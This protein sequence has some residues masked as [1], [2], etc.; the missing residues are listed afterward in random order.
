MKEL[1]SK[2]GNE[3]Y[4]PVSIATL[5]VFAQWL[6]SGV[7]SATLWNFPPFS[8]SP[9]PHLSLYAAP[10]LDLLT[11]AWLGSLALSVLYCG[12]N[13][14]GRLS[15]LGTA[16]NRLMKI[17]LLF[18]PALVLW[19]SMFAE[20]SFL[21]PS[22]AQTPLWFG[23]A[24]PLS[25]II[26]RSVETAIDRK[27]LGKQGLLSIAIN[28]ALIVA[29]IGMRSIGEGVYGNVRYVSSRIRGQP[30]EVVPKPNVKPTIGALLLF[31]SI[32]SMTVAYEM[33]YT[34]MLELFYA[35]GVA[36]YAL[37]I[38]SGV[39]GWR[40]LKREEV[41]KKR[42]VRVPPRF[43]SK[44]NFFVSAL[45]IRFTRLRRLITG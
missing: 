45:S 2:L 27:I 13:R 15:W 39:V 23:S 33:G 6:R 7:N 35:F 37:A 40:R 25:Q 1:W 5:I 32:A 9:F 10:L 12:R 19:F 11:Y 20:T 18:Y 3:K 21:I 43:R 29:S 41:E 42:I 34:S 28:K 4:W 24:Y 14:L 8:A 16:S 22:W 26:F 38:A 30:L 36:P 44:F 17:T 31:L